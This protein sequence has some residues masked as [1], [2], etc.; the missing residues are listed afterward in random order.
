MLCAEPM[1][2]SRCNPSL[3]ITLKLDLSNLYLHMTN[4]CL[5]NGCMALIANFAC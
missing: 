2:R 5:S 4:D 3:K 1:R